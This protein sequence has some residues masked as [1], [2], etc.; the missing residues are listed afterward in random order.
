MP[1]MQK[2]CTYCSKW[3]RS[4][5]LKKHL[6]K[7]GTYQSLWNH[8]QRLS[9][10][11]LDDGVNSLSIRAVEDTCNP[12]LVTEKLKILPYHVSDDEDS[13]DGRISIDR[14]D[15]GCDSEG[16]DN[17]DAVNIDRLPPS[18]TSRSRFMSSVDNLLPSPATVSRFL[19]SN[20]EDQL[21]YCFGELFSCFKRN[22]EQKEEIFMVAD[23]FLERDIISPEQ[24]AKIS[25]IL[26]RNH[27]VAD[28]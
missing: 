8:K 17:V 2:E 19:S 14:D 5:N 15:K 10:L 22:G 9:A 28:V 26:H 18:P 25:Y 16:S 11:T 1:G 23:Q 7:C 12:M 3:I 27:G 24:Y 21:V 13:N 20:V 4:D 6:L